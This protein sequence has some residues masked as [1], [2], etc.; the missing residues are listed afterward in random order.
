MAQEM[1]Q[2]RRVC[3]KE[4]LIHMS[5]EKAL[6]RLVSRGSQRKS[7][8]RKKGRCSHELITDK[9]TENNKKRFVFKTGRKVEHDQ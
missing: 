1:Q 4:N 8:K 3:I 2:K 7:Q 5:F 9:N 6:A